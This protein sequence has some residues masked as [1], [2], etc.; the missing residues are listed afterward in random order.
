MNENFH[1]TT[2][3]GCAINNTSTFYGDVIVN[4]ERSPPLI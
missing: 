4:S 1:A 2:V 3:C